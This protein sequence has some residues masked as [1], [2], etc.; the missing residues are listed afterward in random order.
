MPCVIFSSFTFTILKMSFHPDDII[1]FF[2]KTTNILEMNS[3]SFEAASCLRS[4]W[5]IYVTEQYLNNSGSFT[6]QRLCFTHK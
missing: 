5:L 3:E 2:P 1:N 4:D 6:N